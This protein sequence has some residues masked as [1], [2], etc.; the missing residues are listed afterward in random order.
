MQTI[1]GRET[2]GCVADNGRVSL[3]QR[4]AAVVSGHYGSASTTGRQSPL[5][6]ALVAGYGGLP[7]AQIAPVVHVLRDAWVRV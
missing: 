1:R 2:I 3:T 5:P 7:T 6:S 4:K